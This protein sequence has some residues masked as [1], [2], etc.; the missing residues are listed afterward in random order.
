MMSETREVLE[1]LE[2]TKLLSS[3]VNIGVGCVLDK[4]SEIVTALHTDANQPDSQDFHHPNNI[5]VHVAK[6]I[7]ALNNFIFQD[8]WLTQLLAIEPLRI[9]GANIYESFSTL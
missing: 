7:P 9:F 2:V 8:V 4:F 6:L 3:C 5:A 1:S